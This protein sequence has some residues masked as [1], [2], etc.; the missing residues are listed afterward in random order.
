[1]ANDGVIA[2]FATGGTA[3]Y[4][5]KVNNL[6]APSYVTGLPIGEYSIAAIDAN[7]CVSSNASIQL[8]TVDV[9]TNKTVI[10]LDKDKR[11]EV[12][13]VR[14]SSAPTSNVVVNITSTP[15]NIVTVEP[16]ALTF[17]PGDWSTTQ[18][19]TVTI[20]AALTSPP[21]AVSYYTTK[22][23]NRVDASSDASYRDIVR[24]V[25]VNVTDK[26]DLNCSVFE[27]NLPVISLNG[28]IENS[29]YIMCASDDQAHVLS[30]NVAG[31]VTYRWLRDN[32]IGVSTAASYQPS[33]GGTYT[34]TAQNANYCWTVSEPFVVK[35]EIAPNL[36]V[37]VGPTVVRQGE[38]KEYKIKYPQSTVEYKWTLPYG[39][40]L[41]SGFDN[42][43]N[44]TIKIG[45]ASAALTVKATN[46]PASDACPAVE[47]RL[48]I[49]VTPS[50]IIDVYPTVASNNTPLTIVPK[51][52]TIDNLSVISVVGESHAYK[53][54][55]GHLSVQSG[56][57]LQITIPGLSSGHYFVVFYGRDLDGRKIVHT[58][59]IIFKN[60]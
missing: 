14:L 16:A 45:E 21:N 18:S 10:N 28:R 25:I 36:P 11:T 22:I 40:E 19:A 58:E 30:T 4:T 9:I 44:I 27:Q 1:V 7:G 48:N 41:T 55:S 12:Y 57:M 51:N 52:V 37:I 20:A 47:G 26:G 2:L 24:E 23:V 50:Y 8:K 32:V 56:E 5:Y 38:D 42:D 35:K 31:A 6:P 46:Q 54:V 43:R 17:T 13:T 60:N 15:G 59:Q 49:Q 34:V 39:Y 3:P 29:P 33:E 53:I